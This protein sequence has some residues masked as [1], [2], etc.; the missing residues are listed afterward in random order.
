VTKTGKNE[1]AARKF[2]AYLA[3]PPAKAL[4]EK[5]GFLPAR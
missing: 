5:Y 1:A 4:F 3:S 2:A